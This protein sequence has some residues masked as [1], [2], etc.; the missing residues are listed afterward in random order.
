MGF[1]A[2]DDLQPSNG[3]RARSTSG[4]G[5]HGI[6]SATSCQ[7][8]SGHWVWRTA[9]S[10]RVKSNNP[11][12][13][14]HQ[15][16]ILEQ[17]CHASFGNRSVWDRI[18]LFSQHLRFQ[19]RS[20]A[21]RPPS[22]DTAEKRRHLPK[23]KDDVSAGGRQNEILIRVHDGLFKFTTADENSG[24]PRF[25][26]AAVATGD[27]GHPHDPLPKPHFH[28]RIIAPAGC[29]S[30]PFHESR[31]PGGALVHFGRT[32]NRSGSCPQRE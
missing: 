14:V 30:M 32:R 8:M 26:G 7:T 29:C 27:S 13:K 22:K 3:V 20:A 19:T 6:S 12:A 5:G 17:P 25:V 24:G 18:P 31:R 16:P 21:S 23:A 11:Q 4:V 10:L 28:K 9:S 2:E 1:A 15:R